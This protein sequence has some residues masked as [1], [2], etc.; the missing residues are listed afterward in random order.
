MWCI[1]SDY[2]D[3]IVLELSAREDELNAELKQLTHNDTSLAAQAP[4][5][6]TCEPYN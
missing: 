3:E 5:L 6:R 4:S 2:Y 1:T